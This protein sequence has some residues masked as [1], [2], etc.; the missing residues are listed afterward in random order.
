MVDNMPRNTETGVGTMRTLSPIPPSAASVDIPTPY[1]L[2]EMIV[3]LT[4]AIKAHTKA[5]DEWRDTDMEMFK[6]RLKEKDKIIYLIKENIKAQKEQ[7]DREERDKTRW[8]RVSMAL[9]TIVS[10]LAGLKVYFDGIGV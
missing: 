6:Q 7:L 4:A 8:F 9:I 2:R 3:Q 10:G 5:D 1:T